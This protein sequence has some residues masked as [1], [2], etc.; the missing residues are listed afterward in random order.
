MLLMGSYHN[1]A[2]PGHNFFQSGL[3]EIEH[4]TGKVCGITVSLLLLCI[5][6]V[7]PGQRRKCRR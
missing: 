4:I 3:A 1:I 7:Q 5:T 6:T 2:L